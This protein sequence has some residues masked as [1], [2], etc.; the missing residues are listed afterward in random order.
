M[1]VTFFRGRLGADAEKVITPSG[2]VGTK[3]SLGVSDSYLN[4]AGEW[5]QR[6]TVWVACEAWRTVAETAHPLLSSGA[7]VIVVGKWRAS[8]WTT[9]DGSKRH[10]NTFYVESLGINAADMEISGVK[11]RVKSSTKATESDAAGPEKAQES[12]AASEPAPP[13]EQIPNPFLAGDSE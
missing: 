8:S 7:A 11:K 6:E 13:A 5:V 1:D 2:V 12:A 4:K 10:K 3:F 9:E